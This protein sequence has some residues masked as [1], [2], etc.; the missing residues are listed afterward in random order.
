MLKTLKLKKAEL[1]QIAKFLDRAPKIP[2]AAS[3]ELDD[4]FLH[5]VFL[6][7]EL[8]AQSFKKHL[9][10]NTN[11]GKLTSDWYGF[12][13]YH[14][15]SRQGDPL[16]GESQCKQVYPVA[17]AGLKSQGF[18]LSSGQAAT[19]TAI[20]ALTKR[21]RLRPESKLDRVY[22][23]TM[24]LID[25]L[26]P[27]EYT[28]IFELQ[29]SSAL[30]FSWQGVMAGDKKKILL[31]DTTCIDRKDSHLKKFLAHVHKTLRP[32]ILIRSCVKLDSCGAEFGMLGSLLILNPE[33]FPESRDVSRGDRDTPFRAIS[34][35]IKT[36]AAHMGHFASI[37]SIYPFLTD[38]DM[39]EL[40]SQR[41]KRIQANTQRLVNYLTDLKLEVRVRP[42]SLFCE[43]PHLGQGHP[44]A[45]QKLAEKLSVLFSFPLHFADS[46]GLDVSTVTTYQDFYDTAGTVCLR[47]AP[48]DLLPEEFEQYLHIYGRL[49]ERLKT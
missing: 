42:H 43:I 28:G 31:F 45:L 1:V 48:P 15:Y 40:C 7:R 17:P 4:F 20:S 18:F 49:V 26:P 21:F 32:V 36:T 34:D 38:P 16:I 29:D 14:R 19:H 10:P 12:K 8:R 24:E 5:K 30:N 41:V 2:A 37:D 25:R 23:E 46:F 3:K 33:S 44:S 6:Q 22:F 35:V 9:F 13:F 27:H 39:T 47:I 11:V